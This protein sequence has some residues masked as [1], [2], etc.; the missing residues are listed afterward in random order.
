MNI[1]G[2]SNPPSIHLSINLFIYYL[3][4]SAAKKAEANP[5]RL[6][7]RGGVHP[8]Q[9]VNLSQRHEQPLTLMLTPMGN[10][11][12]V[13]W[14]V[15]QCLDYGR[16]PEE[17]H[18][19]EHTHSAQQVWTQ[20]LP[21]NLCSTVL[22]SI[23]WVVVRLWPCRCADRRSTVKSVVGW[24]AP[25]LSC[26]RSLN[27]RHMHTLRPL[28]RL[29]N[30]RCKSRDLETPAVNC[31]LHLCMCLRALMHTPPHVVTESSTYKM[32]AA[33]PLSTGLCNCH[34]SAP[35]G[36]KVFRNRRRRQQP[37]F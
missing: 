26:L 4:H 30:L 35:I 14:P 22:P 34:S 12:P 8:G 2:P 24:H 25:E 28:A 37:A 16:K 11:K 23:W 15:S 21:A 7:V 31:L 3:Y 10:L 17:T 20:I 32:D 9:V 5:S 18:P 27:V 1:Y 29:L 19:G 13:S 33:D 6:C 36:F